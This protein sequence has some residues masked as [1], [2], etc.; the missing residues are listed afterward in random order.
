MLQ[1]GGDD[2]RERGLS[3]SRHVHLGEDTQPK[4]LEDQPL[5]E[6]RWPLSDSLEQ[7]P[8][9]SGV[10]LRDGPINPLLWSL[11]N[12]GRLFQYVAQT[13]A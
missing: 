4:N 11:L 13:L 8:G 7:F 1:G 10:E 2:S 9:D 5:K 3:A 6:I 12:G